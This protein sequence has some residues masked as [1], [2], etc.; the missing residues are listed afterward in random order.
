MASLGL[1][2]HRLVQSEW[3]RY[4]LIV[5]ERQNVAQGRRGTGGVPRPPLPAAAGCCQACR[6]LNEHS[7]QQQAAAQPLLGGCQDYLRPHP[8]DC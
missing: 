7:Q 2:L 5:G 6:G 8:T 1:Q 3:E 4:S